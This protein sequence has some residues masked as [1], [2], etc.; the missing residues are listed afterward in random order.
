M[1]R[2]LTVD[3]VLYLH[4]AGIDKF[5]GSAGLRDRAALESAI[6][7]PQ[8]G[9]YDDLISEAAAL[10]ESL[11]INHPFI[12]GNKRVAFS[13]TDIFL[14]LNG[15]YLQIDDREFY[16]KMIHLFET[17]NFKHTALDALL[18][19]SIVPYKNE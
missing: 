2:Y 6:L 19:P 12:D 17:Q 13:V 7:R 14:R 4:K 1:T 3:E 10:L 8:S 15:L 11:A 18:R 16:Q 9:Y 5:G